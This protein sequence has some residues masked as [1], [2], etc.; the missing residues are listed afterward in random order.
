[1]DKYVKIG[2]LIDQVFT[3]TKVGGYQF[4]MWSPTENKMLVSDTWE[5]GYQKKYRVETD[6]GILELSSSQLSQLLEGVVK[7]GVAD[8]NGRS[9]QV[10]SNGKT[11]LEVRYY[12]NPVTSQPRPQSIQDPEVKAKL[13]ANRPEQPPVDSYEGLSDAPIDLSDVPF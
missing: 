8:I 9:F 7:D 13:E 12:L 1:M 4:K 11:G 5:K 2:A 10:K 6:K 3:V